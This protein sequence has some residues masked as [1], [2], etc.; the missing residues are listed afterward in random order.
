MCKKYSRLIVV[1]QK[2][3]KMPQ[4]SQLMV[5]LGTSNLAEI[6]T[7]GKISLCDCFEGGFSRCQG[8]PKVG[9]IIIPK[10]L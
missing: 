9:R 2:K 5:N 3:K 7:M 1:E 6:R 4:S 10:G 8:D